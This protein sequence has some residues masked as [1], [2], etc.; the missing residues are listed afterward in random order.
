MQKRYKGLAALLVI[1]LL[2]SLAPAAA[3]AVEIEAKRPSTGYRL[4]TPVTANLV[5]VGFAGEEWW[6][7]GN[8]GDGVYQR[9]DSITLLVRGN[10]TPTEIYGTVAFRSGSYTDPSDPSYTQYTAGDNCWY[11]NNPGET[12]GWTTASDY[13]GSTLQ[14]KMEDIAAGINSASPKEYALI[15]ARTLTIAD[16]IIGDTVANQKLWPLSYDEYAILH[17]SDVTMYGRNGWWLR[18]PDPYYV[19]IYGS[20]SSVYRASVISGYGLYSV[21]NV[22]EAR[23]A[24]SLDLSNAL[25]TS[26]A[27][28][29]KNVAVGDTLSAAEATIDDTEVMT[30]IIGVIKFTMIDT[31]TG[32][33]NLIVPDT[34]TR[35][36]NPGDTVS[37]D[38]SGAFAGSDNKFVSGIITDNSGKVLY[39]GKLTEAASGTANIVVP[40]GLTGGNYKIKI[41]NEQINGDKFT[42]FASEPI[43]ITLTVNGGRNGRNSG[44]D[45]RTSPVV[46][47]PLPIQPPKTGD[48]MGAAWLLCVAGGIAL[49]AVTLHKKRQSAK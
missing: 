6:F 16:G 23:P 42:D 31:N 14:L 47:L 35:T 10:M 19:S 7:I 48:G 2:L 24:F 44:D 40:S 36:A 49:A 12:P 18:S 20:S 30:F 43:T 29:G 46:T 33:L 39:Y 21:M 5:T 32:F 17:R 45:D 8:S 41:F 28:G 4:P 38:Y 3:M 37:I 34:T 26:A 9:P 13:R 27:V 1:L 11:K 22:F 15:Q 25:F